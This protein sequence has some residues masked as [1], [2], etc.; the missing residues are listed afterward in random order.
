M[1]SKSLRRFRSALEAAG[2]PDTVVE[3]DVSARTALDAADALGCAVGQ[4][5]KSLVLSDD[6]HE[7]LLVLAAGDMR[8]DLERIGRD[9]GRPVTMA[10][11]AFVREVTGYAIGGVPPFGHA[12]GL[13]TLVDASLLRWSEIWAAAGTPRTVFSLSPDDLLCVAGGMTV[14]VC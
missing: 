2:L 13:P 6:E 14:K 12:R 7:P 11:A 4:I 8:V 9:H 3:L 10:D 1:A 5:V